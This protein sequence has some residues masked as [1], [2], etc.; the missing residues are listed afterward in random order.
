MLLLEDLEAFAADFMAERP[1]IENHFVVASEDK[2]ARKYRNIRNAGDNCTMAVVIP[3]HDG[4]IPDEDNR[5]F[6]DNLFFVFLKKTNQKNGNDISSFKV[7][8]KECLAMVKKVLDLHENF[9][10]NCIF[11]FVD[12]SSFKVD[13]LEDYLGGDG[14]Q[15]EYSM[16][17]NF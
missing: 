1:N 3:S 10:D 4:D 6:R 14:Y 17:T 2:L 13:P 7:C 12:L 11:R 5:R 16:R 8:Q 9:G 15:I